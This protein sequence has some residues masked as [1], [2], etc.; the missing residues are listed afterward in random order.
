[1]PFGGLFTPVGAHRPIA[2][3]E[4]LL[5]YVDAELDVRGPAAE[6][7]EPRTGKADHDACGEM[8]SNSGRVRQRQ[9]H[10]V[11]RYR[12]GAATVKLRVHRDNRT[13]EDERLIDEVT[14]EVIQKPARHARI[15]LFAPT[16]LQRRT[17]AVEARIEAYQ[18]SE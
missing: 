6:H 12:A 13:T 17:P 2:P 3:A 7:M 14:A 1:M 8:R 4:S 10:V 16:A 11:I 5:L 18:L 15:A 9:E